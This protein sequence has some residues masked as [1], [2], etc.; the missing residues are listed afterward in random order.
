M[1][2]KSIVLV[3]LFNIPLYNVIPIV[4]LLYRPFFPRIVYCIDNSKKDMELKKWNLTYVYYK[5]DQNADPDQMNY[6]CVNYVYQLASWAGGFLFM[7]DDLLISP[8]AI[9]NLSFSLPALHHGLPELPCSI[10]PANMP[11]CEQFIK[12]TR[13]Q[14]QLSSLHQKLS[15]NP[16]DSLGRRCTR[17]FLNVTGQRNKAFANSIADI[18]F[19]PTSFMADA[20]ELFKTSYESQI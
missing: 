7:A 16:P 9:S 15:K 14:G 17:N 12:Y 2:F 4:E 1:Q 5:T 3:V 11:K 19:I 20:S 13:R 8:T 10:D 18:Y 6:I